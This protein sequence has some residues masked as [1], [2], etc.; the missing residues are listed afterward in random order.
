VLVGIAAAAAGATA[1]AADGTPLIA[2]IR[3]HDLDKAR[4]LIAESA[5]VNALDAQSA[6][7]LHWAAHTNDEDAVELLLEAGANP[8]LANRFGVTPLHEAATVGNADMLSAMLDAGGDPN[9]AFGA[10]ETVLMTA[11]RVGNADAVSALLMHGARVDAT[12]GWHGQ[13]ALMWAAMENHADV[14]ELLLN[15]GA[16]VDRA[17]LRHDW[18]RIDAADGDA[19]KSRDVGGLTALQFAARQGATAAVDKLLEHGANA[20]A[21]EPMYQL[22]SL[23]IAIANGHYTLAKKLIDRGVNVNDGSLYLAI[24]TRNLGHYPQRPNPPDKDGE[25]T[26]LD[27][28]AALLEHGANPNLPYTKGIPERGVGGRIDVPR[29]AT[30]LDRATAAGDSR[31][32]EM[33]VA[34]GAKPR[35]PTGDD[36]SAGPR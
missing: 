1:A 27:V 7:A 23:Q 9:A 21:V 20:N 29:G 32:I 25:V 6:S 4:S 18:V 34:R 35:P 17:S 19:P 36:A 26:S 24:D 16:R 31:V 2:A 8:N 13:T 12:E 33:L 5:P 22:S 11:A 15:A 30:P 28:I 10:G 3:A 14:V